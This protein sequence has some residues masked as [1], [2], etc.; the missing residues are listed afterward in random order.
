VSV[1]FLTKFPLF[2]ERLTILFA[3]MG[4]FLQLLP[5]ILKAAATRR[6]PQQLRDAGSG[7]VIFRVFRFAK[8]APT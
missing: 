4:G 7:A 1:F 2:R 3:I 8:M 6:Q 5:D